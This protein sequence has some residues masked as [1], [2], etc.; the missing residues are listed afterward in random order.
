MPIVA[1]SA[2]LYGGGK[3]RGLRIPAMSLPDPDAALLDIRR[4]LKPNRRLLFVEHGPSCEDRVSRW[5]RWL[6]P[7][8]RVLTGGCHHDRHVSELVASAGFV[9]TKLETAYISGPMPMTF[10][11]EGIA[12]RRS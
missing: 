12:R 5:Q 4:V 1:V 6:T 3:Q 7:C 2:N 10:I 8:W 9:L 11:Y